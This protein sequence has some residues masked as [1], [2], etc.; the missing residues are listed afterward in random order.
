MGYINPISLQKTLGLQLNILLDKCEICIE[1]KLTNQRNKEI[2]PKAKVHLEKVVTN[3]CGPISPKTI[4]GER[5]I[6]FFLDSATRYLEFKLL[7]SKSE[8][9]KAF[10]EFKNWAEN[11]LKRKIQYLKLD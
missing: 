4:N 2:T 7:K 8:A 6:I 5:Y 3:L 9:Y 11:L 10:I 1:L